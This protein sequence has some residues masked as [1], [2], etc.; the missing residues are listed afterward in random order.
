[1]PSRLERERQKTYVIFYSDFSFCKIGN[2]V[3]CIPSRGPLGGGRRRESESLHAFNGAPNPW[4]G[5]GHSNWGAL[6][7]GLKNLSQG[8]LAAAMLRQRMGGAG[9][10]LHSTLLKRSPMTVR[11]AAW[12]MVLR[13]AQWPG[14]DD[15]VVVIV[16]AGS[17]PWLSQ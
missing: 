13:S 3:R 1:R 4:M 9:I 10:R 17:A 8:Y 5:P 16:A 6:M 2:W 12:R 14:P 7:G 11:L 15:Q